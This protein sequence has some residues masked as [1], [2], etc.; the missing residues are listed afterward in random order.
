M[1]KEEVGSEVHE[2]SKKLYDCVDFTRILMEIVGKRTK[3]YAKPYDVRRLALHGRDEFF[4]LVSYMSRLP[5]I[6]D[7]VNLD[8]DRDRPICD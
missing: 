4:E 1:E 6:K 7:D 3:V 5:H 2:I 8:F